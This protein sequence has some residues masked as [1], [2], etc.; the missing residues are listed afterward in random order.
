MR[1]FV[2][3]IIN[4]SKKFY[5]VSIDPYKS[6]YL[7]NIEYIC[8]PWHSNLKHHAYKRKEVL[9]NKTLK[10]KDYPVEYKKFLLGDK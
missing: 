9:L 4:N 8:K 3:P 6:E 5:K 10:H 1:R 7:K 2:L